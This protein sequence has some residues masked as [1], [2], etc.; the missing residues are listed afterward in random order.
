MK[1]GTVAKIVAAGV[2][3]AAMFASA[4]HAEG[5]FLPGSEEAKEVLPGTRQVERYHVTHDDVSTE[6]EYARR[7]RR[8]KELGRLQSIKDSIF[9]MGV[10]AVS[11]A[12][13]TVLK[14]LGALV[15]R[16]MGASVTALLGFLGDVV[17]NFIIIAALFSLAFKVL[18]P[19]RSLRELWTVKNVLIM[20]TASL[21]IETLR[22]VCAL[23]S[24]RAY[25]ISEMIQC[26]MTMG[27]IGY[28]Y[29][30]VFQLEGMF[31]SAVQKALKSKAG[32][33]TLLGLSFGSVFAVLVKTFLS[34]FRRFAAFS[35]LT[36]VF[37]ICLLVVICG[38]KLFRPVKHILLLKE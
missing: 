14:L 24:S 15:A 13:K 32:I 17:I 1:K 12:A 9:S 30:R 22:Y 21:L 7:L 23:F 33:Y 19:G 34:G 5:A 35:Q 16:L 20:I 38:I 8:Q 31:A 36:G 11:V 25:F 4:G 6:D 2:M 29:Y 37:I 18:F 26:L 10:L 3:S 28:A 27:I